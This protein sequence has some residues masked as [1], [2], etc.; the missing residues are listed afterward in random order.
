MSF[1]KT[2]RKGLKGAIKAVH[3]DKFT[4]NGVKVRCVHCQHEHFKS[5]DAQLNTASLTFLNLDWANK[6]A[7]VL[8]CKKCSHI[9]WFAA[10]AKKVI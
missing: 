7:S 9:M 2:M 4:V 3:S 10:A 6:S 5:D 1:F 8:V